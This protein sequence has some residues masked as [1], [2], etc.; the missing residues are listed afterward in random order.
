M[1]TNFLA[2]LAIAGAA[3]SIATTAQA[4]D[5]AS[6]SAPAYSGVIEMFGGYSMFSGMDEFDN[7]E[8]TAR[9]NNPILGGF[10]AV[11]APL[12]DGMS[13]QL[14][15][16]S[17]ALFAPNNN[18]L[19]EDEMFSGNS[20]LAVHVSGRNEEMLFGAFGGAGQAGLQGDPDAVFFFGGAEMQAYLGSATL[21][22]QGGYL[23]SY[24][25]DDSDDDA[26]D[27]AFFARGI[28]RLYAS[29]TSRLSTEVAYADGKMDETEDM[30]IIGWGARFDQQMSESP[31][32]LFLAYNGNRYDLKED[33]GDVGY[34]HRAMVGLSFAFGG[35]TIMANDRQGVA[36]DTKDLGPWVAIGEADASCGV[37]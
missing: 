13:V 11:N 26:L 21:Y 33:C 16:L 28:A 12:S 34:E 36:L 17:S 32:S 24:Q 14:D 4:A 9:E 3:L 1:M 7:S 27:K 31:V 15:L 37:P 35:N 22:I 29:E 23:D 25:A 10:A 20:Q 5:V 8:A 2:R 19:T 30:A 6:P 18:E